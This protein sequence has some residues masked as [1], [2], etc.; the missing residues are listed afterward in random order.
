MHFR[1]ST[2][3]QVHPALAGPLAEATYREYVS[4]GRIPKWHKNESLLIWHNFHATVALKK[5]QKHFFS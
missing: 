1:I 3:K 2:I 5:Y 4:K